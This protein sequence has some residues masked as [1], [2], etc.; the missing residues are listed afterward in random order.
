MYLS[1]FCQLDVLVCNSGRSQ[2]AKWVNIEPE[3]DKALFDVNV[4]SLVS[5]ARIAVRYF[6]ERYCRMNGG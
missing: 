5:L 6:L 3:V 2:R 4:F 1:S